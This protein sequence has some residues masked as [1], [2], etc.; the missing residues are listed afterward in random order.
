MTRP[1]TTCTET[2]NDPLFNTPLHVVHPETGRAQVYDIRGV[3][4]CRYCGAVWH[5]PWRANFPR[6]LGMP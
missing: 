1:C 5:R 3:A 4:V 2:A 6:L